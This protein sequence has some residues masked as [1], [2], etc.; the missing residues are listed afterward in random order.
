MLKIATRHH[1]PE[2]IYDFLEKNIGD[3]N[4]HIKGDFAIIQFDDHQ[5]YELAREKFVSFLFN[6]DSLSLVPYSE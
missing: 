2:K 6:D 3:L 5:H 1:D 4:M